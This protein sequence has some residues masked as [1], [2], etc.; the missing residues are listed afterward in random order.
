MQ[1]EPQVTF[2]NVNPSDVILDQI[3]D[4]LA[5]LG[6]T[7]A[8]IVAC[9]VVLERP[10]CAARKIDLFRID[11]VLALKGGLEVAISRDPP[12]TGREDPESAV[13]DA[14]EIAERRFASR[15]SGKVQAARNARSVFEGR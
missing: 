1:L 9:R 14:F 6:R 15:L 7:V 11:L 10:P 3:K 8:G 5:T 12:E 13:R 2:K 4:R